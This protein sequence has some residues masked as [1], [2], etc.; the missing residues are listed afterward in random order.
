VS[1]SLIICYCF[2]LQA[3]VIGIARYPPAPKKFKKSS[4]AQ[5][6]SMNDQSD[7]WEELSIPVVLPTVSNLRRP[8]ATKSK[9]SSDNECQPTSGTV[10]SLEIATSQTPVR[11]SEHKSSRTSVTNSGVKSQSSSGRGSSLK[12]VG[13]GR[14]SGSVPKSI[15]TPVA[16]VAHSVTPKSSANN[17]SKGSASHSV[18]DSG[19][20][21]TNP[22]KAT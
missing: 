5:A 22:G 15:T 4:N 21:T 14:T 7:S 11:V 13:K 17:G 1:A 9:A 10:T 12:E 20:L 8:E 6:L 19:N 18:S 16:E 2:C 3:Q